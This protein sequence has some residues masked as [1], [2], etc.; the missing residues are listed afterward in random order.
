MRVGDADL[1]RLLG[2][3]LQAD[4][5]RQPQVVAR[6][7]IRGDLE[8]ARRLPPRIDG[9]L[10][11]AVVSAQVLVV[12]RLD[13][14]LADDVAELVALAAQLLQLRGGDLPVVAE[15]LRGERLIRVAPQ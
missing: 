7:R 5:D 3:T 8:L 13:P 10:R 14:G 11:G 15:Y 12:G 4:V 2:G 9:Q 1:Q 6:L